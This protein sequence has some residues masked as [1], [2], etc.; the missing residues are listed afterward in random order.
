MTA[1]RIDVTPS[2]GSPPY[3]VVVGVGVLSELPGL[4][5][6]GARTVVVIHAEGL[7][8]IAR[9]ACG[10]LAAA[11]YQVHAEPVPD[12]EAAKTAE[13]AAG[14]WSRLGRHNVTRSDCIVGIG[15]GATTD[16]GVM[17]L[18]KSSADAVVKQVASEQG[19]T[20][21]G[22]PHP[23]RGSFYR[24]DMFSLARVGVP[25]V[26]VKGG[27]D[28]KGRPKGWGDPCPRFAVHGMFLPL[29]TRLG[30]EQAE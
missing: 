21:H 28:Y 12:G 19:R 24:S 26:A 17:G 11:G 3:Q 29:V 20:V 10:A 30:V 22:D 18:G 15:G 13:V 16:L 2:D 14:L 23:D 4:V 5:P 27:P 25:P 1:T 8:E 9:P 6:D 7:G